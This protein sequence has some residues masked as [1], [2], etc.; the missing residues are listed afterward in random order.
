LFASKY[1]YVTFD[2]PTQRDRALEDPE[3]FLDELGKHV[4]LEEVQ[5]VPSIFSSIKMRVDEAR[6]AR[7]QYILTGS[8]QFGLMKNLTETLAGRIGLL[9]LLPFSSLEE[10]EAAGRRRSGEVQFLRCTQRGSF[11]ELI[12]HPKR[13]AVAWYES[14]LNTYLERDVRGLHNVGHLRD[15]RRFLVVLASRCSQIFN[16]SRCAND[17]GV[18]VPTISQWLSI[19]EA[20][21]IIFFLPPYYRNFGKRVTKS[22]KVYF[23]DT[24]L[25]THL[26]GT[27]TNT[28][29]FHGPMSGALFEN[30][31]V[32][33][34]AKQYRHRGRAP[35]IYFWRAN[36][37]LE[38]DLLIEEGGM[39]YPVECKL[40]KTIR[41]VMAESLERFMDAVPREARGLGRMVSL[42]S[43]PC[44]LTRQVRSLNVLDY[45]SHLESPRA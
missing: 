7:G 23:W 6:E 30:Y 10:M 17:I 44:R 20:S 8:Q 31:V 33:E 22:P 11:P 38:V 32:S 45:L 3:L 13:D 40:H 12:A 24:G 37:G 28:Q 43:H 29:V 36:S 27:D 34:T 14:Y 5:Y 16:M 1:R 42:T 25:V 4:I 41:P 2:S 15:F 18:S 19:L 26:M 39:L 21:W 9:A 35:R